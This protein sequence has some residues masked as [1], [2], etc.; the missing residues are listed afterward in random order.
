MK[1]VAI[2]GNIG[3]GKSWVCA[4]FEKLGIPVFYSDPEAKQLYYRADIREAMKARFGNDIYRSDKEINKPLLSS[5]IFNDRKAMRDVERLLYP[6]L[7]AWFDEWAEQQ[8]AP[9]VLYESAIIFEKHL[10]ERFDASIMVTASRKTRLRRVMLR[11]H[12]A[13]EVVRERMKKQWSDNKKSALADFVITHDTDDDD[14]AL[15]QQVMQVHDALTRAS[16]SNE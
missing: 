15:M 3:S 7:N 16:D 5:L 10:A 14:E 8:D 6:A 2:T 11:D 13:A 12:C 4:L 1:K 9:Y